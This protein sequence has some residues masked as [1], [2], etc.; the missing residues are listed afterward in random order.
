MLKQGRR[1]REQ[2]EDQKRI[3][4]EHSAKAA[5]AAAASQCQAVESVRNGIMLHASHYF[6]GHLT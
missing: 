1:F 4:N 3:L 6:V 5:Q 2:L